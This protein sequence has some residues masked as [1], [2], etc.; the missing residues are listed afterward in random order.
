MPRAIPSQFSPLLPLQINSNAEAL[1]EGS[2]F[3]QQR[4]NDFFY[5]DVEKLAEHLMP[6]RQSLQQEVYPNL[7]KHLKK[8]TAKIATFGGELEASSTNS[9]AE[10]PAVAPEA[11]GDVGGAQA[12]KHV[13]QELLDADTLHKSVAPG[14]NLNSSCEFIQAACRNLSA[15]NTFVSALATAVGCTEEEMTRFIQGEA[16]AA[17]QMQQIQRMQPSLQMFEQWMGHVF[18]EY[19]TAEASF[20]R[21]SEDAPSKY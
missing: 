1:L 13:A 10:V 16:L 18:Q 14:A 17:E 9:S 2:K 21:C 11:R 3:I 4:L 12:L 20:L 8:V 15:H 5:C 7:E 6:M 19:V